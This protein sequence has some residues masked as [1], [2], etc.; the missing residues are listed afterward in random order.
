MME[1]PVGVM[2]CWECVGNGHVQDSKQAHTLAIP[3]IEQ[4]PNKLEKW[5]YIYLAGLTDGEGSFTVS[6]FERADR[7]RRIRY[8]PYMQITSSNREVM[9]WLVENF[10]GS[11]RASGRPRAYLESE[12]RWI[13]RTKP[14]WSW[15]LHAGALRG[16]L[17]EILP[18]LI[19]KKKEAEVMLEALKG[20]D[21]IWAR[22]QILKMRE[23]CPS[24]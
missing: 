10:G 23:V 4:A 9:D 19:I 16:I 2:Q 20:R 1:E 17:P 22:E 15:L 7:D 6:K 18:Y 8:E 21:M 11:Y 24:P 12:Q 3:H 5:K 13:I 14:C